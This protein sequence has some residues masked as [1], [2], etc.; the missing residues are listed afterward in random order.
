MDEELWMTMNDDGRLLMDDDASG[1]V[2][3]RARGRTS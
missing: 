2:P 3:R 1:T